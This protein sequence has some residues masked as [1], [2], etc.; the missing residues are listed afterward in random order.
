METRKTIGFVLGRET[1][2]CAAEIF[3]L[4]ERGQTSYKVEFFKPPI[5]II[6]QFET[7]YPFGIN[8]LGGTIKIFQ[9]LD[10]NINN[11]QLQKVLFDLEIPQTDQRINFGLSGY[12]KI[13]QKF[14]YRIGKEL[15]NHYLEKG[16]KARLVTGKSLDLSSVIVTEN[17]LLTRGFELILIKNQ[18]SYILGK[19]IAVQDYK[20]YGKRDFGR[21]KRDDR[22]GL[23]PPKVAQIMI[24]LAQASKDAT[25]YD[26]F[27]GSGTI[28][29]EALLLGYKNVFGSDISEKQIADTRDN[30]AWLGASICS[31]NMA[32]NHLFVAD[33]T[34]HRPD[35]LTGAIVSE[36][37][38]GKPNQKTIKEAEIEIKKLAIFYEKAINNLIGVIF[39]NGVIVLAIPFFIINEK[40]YY[41]P[42]ID[43]LKGC[44]IDN[45]LPKDIRVNLSPRN[46]LTYRRSG[47]FVGRE[48]L[49]LIRQ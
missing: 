44:K 49:I 31:I 33:A 13:S 6:S 15:K 17:K 48:I 47:Q 20:E 28:L 34:T 5:L 3:A 2:L 21:P 36:G 19:T 14:I 4:L 39:V 29:Q 9:V 38:L 1:A 12:G 41:L 7:I 35:F 23:L 18:D 27:C 8:K 22:N 25:I 45:P 43:K 10:I 46:T 16:L 26:P 32:E 11:D 24:N 30:L 37:D 40:H 42:I